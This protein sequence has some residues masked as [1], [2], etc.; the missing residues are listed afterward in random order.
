MKQVFFLLGAICVSFI[1]F[2][3][4]KPLDHSV[5]DGWQSIGERVISNDGKYVVYTI[6]PQEGDATLVIQ[7]SDN[8][9]KKEIARGYNATISEDNR[10]VVFRI[11]PFF[12][13]TREAKIKKNTPD[14]MPKDS[15]G[16]I[17]LGKD[18]VLKIARVKSYKTPE[19]GSG[20]LAYQLDKA[21]P[22]TVKPAQPD[23]LTKLN[24][25]LLYCAGYP[26]LLPG[27]LP[28][29]ADY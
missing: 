25:L 20:W 18:S 27:Y 15:L 16:I 12:K 7:T 24:N 11:K 22:E 4:K 5:Y 14:Q 10:F 17:E 26:L 2:S 19:K 8:S 6:N 3:Q 13:D 21:L 28:Y 29:A 1:S 23:S 9:Y